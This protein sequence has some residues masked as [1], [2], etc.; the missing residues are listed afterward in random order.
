VEDGRT[1]DMI[2]KYDSE[3]ADETWIE[4]KKRLHGLEEGWTA[5]EQ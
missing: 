5:D 3:T 1:E 2:V 4:F